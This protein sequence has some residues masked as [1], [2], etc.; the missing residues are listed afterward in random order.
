LLV[1]QDDVVYVVEIGL[2]FTIALFFQRLVD[3]LKRGGARVAERQPATLS[4][5]ARPDG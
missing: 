4:G 3:I 5:V 2:G 1:P